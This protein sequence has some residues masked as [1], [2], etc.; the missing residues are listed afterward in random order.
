[1]AVSY[2]AYEASNRPRGLQARKGCKDSAN[3]LETKKGVIKLTM[4]A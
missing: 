2:K 3:F 1:M 4:L